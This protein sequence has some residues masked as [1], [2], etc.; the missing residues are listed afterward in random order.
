MAKASQSQS[1]WPNIEQTITRTPLTI[2]R[3]QAGYL[4]QQT[5]NII[6]G[7]VKSQQIPNTNTVGHYFYIVAPALGNYRYLLLHVIHNAAVLYPLEIYFDALAKKNL[8]NSVIDTPKTT[9][10]TQELIYDALLMSVNRID[11]YQVKNED[12]FTNV[13]QKIFTHEN[14]LNIIR[15]LMAQSQNI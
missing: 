8:A 3:E 4:G 9:S 1:L 11:P 13:L 2:L 14:S 5:S 15:S 10:T 12:E 7:D 6:L